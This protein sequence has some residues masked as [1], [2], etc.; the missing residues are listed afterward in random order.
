MEKRIARAGSLLSLESGEYSD[1]QVHGFFVV[2]QEFE[3]EAEVDAY[4]A[5]HPDQRDQYFER[6]MFIPWL[7]RKGLL[8]EIEHAVWHLTDYGSPGEIRFTPIGSC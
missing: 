3:P 1:Y 2:T 4:F 7:L 8:I 6:S 5:E